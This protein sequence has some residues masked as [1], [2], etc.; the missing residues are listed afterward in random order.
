MLLLVEKSFLKKGVG[1]RKNKHTPLLFRENIHTPLLFRENINTPL[2]FQEN[3][4]ITLLLPGKDQKCRWKHQ[5]R[6]I[7]YCH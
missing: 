4:H 3:I 6:N 2:L 7:K 1:G 5:G